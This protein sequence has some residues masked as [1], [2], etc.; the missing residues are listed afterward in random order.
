M[1]EYLFLSLFIV[2][3]CVLPSIKVFDERSFLNIFSII[4]SE[5]DIFT[6]FRLE[7]M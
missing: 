7:G 2:I 5:R 4:G 1:R 6:C 3:K